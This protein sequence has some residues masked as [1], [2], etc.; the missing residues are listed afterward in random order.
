MLLL[1]NSLEVQ[2]Q[3]PASEEW[4]RALLPTAP[5]RSAVPAAAYNAAAQLLAAEQHVDSH[6]ARARVHLA[7]G[8]WI[9]IRAA[10]I[11][12]Q[13]AVSLE[14]TAPAD[15]LEMFIRTHN[16]TERD[17]TLLELLADGSD[18]KGIARR[19]FLSELTVQDHLKLIFAKAGVHN[20]RSLLAQIL[21]TRAH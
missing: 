9:T 6:E 16:M 7:D 10:R 15:R 8:T 20:R 12:T 2:S 3:T 14:V 11:S 19:M 1:N 21:G 17:G 18:T 5:G 4:L 13:I